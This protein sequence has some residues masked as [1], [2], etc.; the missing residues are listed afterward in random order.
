MILSYYSF[1]FW[2][3]FKQDINVVT[4]DRRKR[5]FTAQDQKFDFN[6][7]NDIIAESLHVD[8]IEIG[9]HL[10]RF[11]CGFIDT[12]Y[13]LVQTNGEKVFGPSSGLEMTNSKN[14]SVLQVSDMTYT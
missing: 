6:L 10:D 13:M 11:V 5:I 14:F 12:K 9:I 1:S 2:N 4:R 3:T 8:E 7:L